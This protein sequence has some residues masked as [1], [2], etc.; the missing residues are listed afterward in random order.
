[1]LGKVGRAETATDPAPLSMIETTI[2]LKPTET[3]ARGQDHRGHH[4]R[5][6]PMV[7]FPGLTN[8]WTMPIKTR[9]DMLATGIKTPVG[10]KLMGAD[11]AA[12]VRAR[13]SRS[14]RWCASCPDT[15]ER[16]LRA[17]RRAATTSTSTSTREDAARYGL[18][19]GDVQDVIQSAIG[20]MNVTWTVEGLER[21]PVNVR[22]PR[23]LRNDLDKLRARGRAHAHGPHGAAGARWPTSRCVKGPPAIKSENARR[24]A[25]IYVDLEDL[26][27]RRLRRAGQGGGGTS[28]SSSRRA[29]PS[30]G[31][32]STSTWSGPTSG[33]PS[34]CR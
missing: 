9:I 10:I 23:E 14:R 4:R 16:L 29:S 22:Y 19:V 30:S 21:Y 6:G 7:Q 13:A 25:W 20:G 27:R 3:V 1:M 11:L 12:A 18:T 5:A 28:R 15:L 33:W 34:W 24:T 8:A 17:G 2:I 26:G 32:A 31:R